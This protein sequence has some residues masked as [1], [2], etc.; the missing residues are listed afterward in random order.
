MSLSAL[1]KL[2]ENGFTLEFHQVSRWKLSKNLR[3]F[4][5]KYLYIEYSF[6]FLQTHLRICNL[7]C[8]RVYCHWVRAGPSIPPNCSRCMELCYRDCDGHRVRRDGGGGD[9]GGASSHRRLPARLLQK[10][11]KAFSSSPLEESF[12][13]IKLHSRPIPEPLRCQYP[14]SDRVPGS[15]FTL[16]FSVLS[17]F[18][19]FRSY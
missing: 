6:Q 10:G 9:G 5:A 12:V 18:W 4:Q 2:C 16:Q 11:T 8:Q 19:G 17:V 13:L 7:F 3:E 14:W 1:L 15:H